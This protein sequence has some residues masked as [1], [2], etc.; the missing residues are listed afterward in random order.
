MSIYQDGVQY[1]ARVDVGKALDEADSI[2]RRKMY[3][4]MRDYNKD[5]IR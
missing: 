5:Q 1:L 2:E 4:D 3:Q